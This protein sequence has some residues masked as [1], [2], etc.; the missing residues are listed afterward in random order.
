M[1]VFFRNRS[2]SQVITPV[3]ADALKTDP[4][5]IANVDETATRQATMVVER[6]ASRVNWL[7]LLVAVIVLAGILAAAIFTAHDPALSNLNTV[8]VHGF[9]L[10]LGGVIGMLVGERAASS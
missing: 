5:T 1:A 8:L 7:T 10:L 2:L 4:K 9:E 6:A 3:L